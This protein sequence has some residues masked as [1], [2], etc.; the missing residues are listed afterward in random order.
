MLLVEFA[1][2]VAVH[3]VVVE[4]AIFAQGANV[5][6]PAGTAGVSGRDAQCRLPS[7][8]PNAGGQ[9]RQTAERGTQQRGK[10]LRL[11]SDAGILHKAEEQRGSPELSLSPTPLQRVSPTQES[12]P[13]F[14]NTTESFPIKKSSSYSKRSDW[15]QMLTVRSSSG[16]MAH[17]K[18]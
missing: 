1:L 2:Q 12:V 3:L 10:G 5:L 6:D 13:I 16:R 8:N 4:G 7:H 14:K 11:C 17:H 9:R 15:K 18:T